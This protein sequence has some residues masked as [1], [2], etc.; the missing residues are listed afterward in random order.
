PPGTAGT[1][2]CFSNANG[3]NDFCRLFLEEQRFD[4]DFA[5]GSAPYIQAA[6]P[7]GFTVQ[8]TGTHALILS[9][10]GGTNY[11]F[12]SV[13]S[14][15]TLEGRQPAC[16]TPPTPTCFQTSVD[17]GKVVVGGAP[18]GGESAGYAKDT[19]QDPRITVTVGTKLAGGINGIPA[20]TADA[21][22][23]KEQL[24][25]IVGDAG[26]L[27]YAKT[28]YAHLLDIQSQLQKLAPPSASG[29]ASGSAPG[30]SPSGSAPWSPSGSA[31]WSPSGSAT[32]SPSGTATW[33]P[34]GSMTGS[35]SSSGSGSS[36]S[37]GSPSGTPATGSHS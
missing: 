19:L 26:F 23:S 27:A 33:W 36:S 29:S 1:E 8:A 4:L 11:L 15:S 7:A 32:W 6:L 10:P 12:P 13:T 2:N 21:L 31:T 14:A 25:K 5:K 37:P 24:A 22:L 20:P 28:Q 35:S 16:S 30:W 9:G 18:S 3:G 17:G 34:S